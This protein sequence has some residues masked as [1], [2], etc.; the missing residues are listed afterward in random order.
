MLGELGNGAGHR[1]GFVG[2]AEQADVVDLVAERHEATM[3]EIQQSLQ[4]YCA[5]VLGG[6]GI[7][8]RQVVPGRIVVVV[9]VDLQGVAVAPSDLSVQV[10]NP[11]QG[12]DEDEEHHLIV[13]PLAQIVEAM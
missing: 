9:A 10:L 12:V 5:L 1:V 6:A 2:H 7:Q 11:G 4:G 8:D 13:Q 3:G